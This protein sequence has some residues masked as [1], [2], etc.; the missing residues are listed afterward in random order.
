MIRYTLI[1]IAFLALVFSIV[2]FIVE[3]SF[4]PIITCLFGIIT[5]IGV[6]R[7]D[8]KKDGSLNL[9][10]FLK[11]LIQNFFPIVIFQMYKRRMQQ[12]SL[13]TT[14]KILSLNSGIV[15]THKIMASPLWHKHGP[16]EEIYLSYYPPGGEPYDFCQFKGN[17]VKL[18]AE[19]FDGDGNQ[20]LAVYYACGA[21]S[22]GFK[23]FRIEQ[24]RGPILVPGTELGSDLPSIKWGDFDKDGRFEIIVKNR[25]WDDDPMRGEV[26]DKY[27]WNGKEYY[28]SESKTRTYENENA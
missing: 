27:L 23:L 12:K 6:Y 15:R 28:L 14:I 11:G 7:S 16:T 20:E 1:L 4:E 19:D 17:S 13:E 26:V 10:I 3:P 18:F 22:R 25:N 5:L 8:V 24:D 9:K 2:W 21:H